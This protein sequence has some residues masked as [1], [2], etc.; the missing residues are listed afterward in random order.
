MFINMD[1]FLITPQQLNLITIH[2]L[3]SI[4]TLQGPRCGLGAFEFDTKAGE[5]S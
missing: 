4:L 2:K 1:P 5:W 3:V